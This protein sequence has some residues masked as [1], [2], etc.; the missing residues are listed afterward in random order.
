MMKPIKY[1]MTGGA[2]LMRWPLCGGLMCLALARPASAA[3][4]LFQIDY[5]VTYVDNAPMVHATNFVNN[6]GSSVSGFGYWFEVDFSSSY[7]TFFETWI[8]SIL[9]TMV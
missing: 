9:P 3:D 1:L 2:R 4:P 5:P 6:A 8:R 7:F